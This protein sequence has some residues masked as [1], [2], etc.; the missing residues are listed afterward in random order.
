MTTNEVFQ[1][2]SLAVVV[3]FTLCVCC[4][5]QWLSKLP[6]EGRGVNESGLQACL[7]VSEH[8][9]MYCKAVGLLFVTSF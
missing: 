8:T 6:L 1:E 2:G 3:V 5:V 9:H 7:C 4:K